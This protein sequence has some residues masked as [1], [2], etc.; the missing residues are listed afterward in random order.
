[1]GEGI[2]VPIATCRLTSDDGQLD[3]TA[4]ERALDL[5]RAAGATVSRADLVAR[6][7]AEE[8]LRATAPQ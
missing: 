8:R 4:F 2:L 7:R 5:E 3:D 1:V 6:R